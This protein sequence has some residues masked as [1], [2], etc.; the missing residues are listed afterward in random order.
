VA[1]PACACTF[2]WIA[3]KKRSGGDAFTEEAAQPQDGGSTGCDCSCRN[4]TQSPY[5]TLLKNGE[6]IRDLLKATEKYVR[7]LQ[8]D[9]KVDRKLM[10]ILG[11]KLQELTGLSDFAF[12]ADLPP[13]GSKAVVLRALCP[14]RDLTLGD[15]DA[16]ISGAFAASLQRVLEQHGLKTVCCNLAMTCWRKGDKEGKELTGAAAG[17]VDPKGVVLQLLA[18]VKQLYVLGLQAAGLTVGGMIVSSNA[19]AESLGLDPN[20]VTHGVKCTADADLYEKIPVVCTAHY[21]YT[22]GRPIFITSV[23]LRYGVHDNPLAV[24]TAALICWAKALAIMTTGSAGSEDD[25]KKFYE[26]L[27]D[28]RESPAKGRKWEDRSKSD[29]SP[30]EAKQ[31]K[32]ELSERVRKIGKVPGQ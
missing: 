27:N 7:N 12:L 1:G 15:G 29:L 13:S 14:L 22:T 30:E 19:P 18:I 8:A 5:D 6:P 11:E 23:A 28:D 25:V 31:L 10:R 3:G 21:K 16:T 26:L 24:A 9:G 17:C 2:R 32:A 4:I 20:S